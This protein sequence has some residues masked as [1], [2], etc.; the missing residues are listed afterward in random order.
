MVFQLLIFFRQFQ[1]LLIPHFSARHEMSVR[2]SDEKGVRL[3]VRASVKRVNCDK[4][5]E[6][7]VQI[8][9]LYERSQPSFQRRR[10]VGGGD[11]FYLKFWVNRPTLERNRRF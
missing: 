9:I 4:T 1:T 6:R 7:C 8:V 2:T 11:P 10:M 3:S 5:E